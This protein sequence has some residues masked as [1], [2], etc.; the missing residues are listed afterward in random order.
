MKAMVRCEICGKEIVP[1]CR[2]NFPADIRKEETY[3]AC[4]PW[5]S[6]E[7]CFELSL[8]NAQRLVEDAEYLLKA[9]RLSSARVLTVLSL[10]ESGKALL[11]CEY[12]TEKKKVSVNDYQNRFLSHPAKIDKALKALEEIDIQLPEL[13][14]EIAKRLQK[15]KTQSIFVDYD[16]R[17]QM[18]SI[19]WSQDSRPLVK[20]YDFIDLETSEAIRE[21][22]EPIIEA[23]TEM[24]IKMAKMAIY[25]ARQRHEQ[26]EMS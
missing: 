8:D 26:I 1:L 9:G 20:T 22:Q 14:R 4:V 21:A 12:L 11:A 3:C 7:Q 24:L 25:C 23:H 13:S 17:F 10:E 2:H 16:G 18:W 19:S 5:E 6:M 15:E